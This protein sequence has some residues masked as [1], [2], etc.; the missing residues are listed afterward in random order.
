MISLRKWSK[1]LYQIRLGTAV[2]LS[3]PLLIWFGWLIAVSMGSYYRLAALSAERDDWLPLNPEL[4]R[5]FIRDQIKRLEL[6]TSATEMPLDSELPLVQMS[7]S[8]EN[9]AELNRDLP[10]SGKSTYFRAYLKWGDETHTVKARYVG[11]NHWHW[12]YPQKSWKIKTKRSQLINGSRLINL[13]NPRT[14]LAF[15]EVIAMELGK[16]LG[17]VAPRVFPV[18]LVLNSQYMGVYLWQDPMEESTIRR[19]RR[20]PGS[21]YSG[22]W[23]P[24]SAMTGVST[25]WDDEKYWEK[26]AARGVEFEAD[27]RD[28]QFFLKSVNDPS[29]EHFY[30]F[31]RRYLNL[32]AYAAYFSLD[33]FTACVYHDYHHNHKLYFDPIIGK[34]ESAAWD[35]SAWGFAYRSLDVVLNP[36]LVKWKLIPEFDYLRHRTLYQELVSGNFTVGKITERFRELGRMVRPSLAA[37]V[38]RDY[39]DLWV[40]RFLKLPRTPMVVYDLAEYEEQLSQ[41]L[42][43]I[44]I[45]VDFLK[46]YLSKSSVRFHFARENSLYLIRVASTGNVAAKLTAL[47]VTGEFDEVRL[48][49]DR[50]SNAMLDEADELVASTNREGE[51]VTLRMSE[52]VYPGYEKIPQKRHALS[53]GAFDLT[54]SPL[55]YSYLVDVGGGSVRSLRWEASNAV[56]GEPIEPRYEEF[57]DQ[58]SAKTISLHPL[59]LPENERSEIVHL[60]PGEILIEGLQEYP[61]HITL[62]IAPGTTIKLTEGASIFCFGKVIAKGTRENPIRF[63]ALTRSRP[64]G[65]LRF[66]RQRCERFYL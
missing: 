5:Y 16:E 52:T 41:Y 23:A 63:Q 13:K 65:G 10:A 58:V 45:R 56:T 48:I 60:G 17:L 2:L 1:S 25:L 55:T 8:A 39:K 11:D 47:T 53:F 6:R 38:F 32:K 37:D 44:E 42:Q 64:W 31:A 54:P 22:D 50:N 24:A 34:F 66:E 43:G 27:R 40:V 49:R 33:N 14:R 51:G 61:A 29:L 15:N 46:A 36:L 21:L 57:S 18:R 20:M 59:L 4:L 28:I 7:V 3:L 12:L 62:E 30:E 35:S 26:S 9:L 19:S